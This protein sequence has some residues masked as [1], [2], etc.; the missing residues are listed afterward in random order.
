MEQELFLKEIRQLIP[1]NT[2]LIDAVAGALDISYDAAHRRTN[3]KS[4]LSLQESIQLA[5]HFKL[6]LDKLFV[7]KQSNWVSVEK[8]APIRNEKELTAYFE[9]SYANLIPLL[10]K[11]GCKLIYSAKDIP[12]FYDLKSDTM[13]RFKLYVWLK[14]LDLDFHSVSYTDFTP[15]LDIQEIAKRL[16]ALYE[17]LPITEIWD[18]TT[19]NGTL[20]QIYF[21]FKAGHLTEK[22]ALMVTASLKETITTISQ[23]VIKDKTYMFYY[24]ELLLMNNNIY[25]QVEDQQSLYIPF[26]L[27]S[28]YRTSDRITCDHAKTYLDKQ[29]QHSKLLNTAGE[30][31]RNSFFNKIHKKIQ[32]LEHLINASETLDF[33]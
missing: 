24:N 15:S 31:E 9:N 22:D 16:G 7:S 4:K 23:R 26:T 25:A 17:D 20:K 18:L 12:I 11:K 30:K 1:T 29:L 13:M 32:A 2:S 28:Y 3:L 21:Y 14:L 5:K 6:S 27:L 10:G 33:E 19:I 8:T